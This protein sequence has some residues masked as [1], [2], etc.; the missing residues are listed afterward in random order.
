[1]GA[2]SHRIDLMAPLALKEEEDFVFADVDP[3]HLLKAFVGPKPTL[4]HLQ[5]VRNAFPLTCGFAHFNLYARRNCLIDISTFTSALSFPWE[6]MA[7]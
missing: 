3:R 4:P 5:C 2:G 1:M 6:F 7:I